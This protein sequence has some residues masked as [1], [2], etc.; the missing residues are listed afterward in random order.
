MIDAESIDRLRD[1]A[2]CEEVPMPSRTDVVTCCIWRH[3]MA[4]SWKI[5][6]SPRTTVLAHEAGLAGELYGE[7][8]LVGNGCR[9]G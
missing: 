6:G 3:A 1:R 9:W 7:C 8:L 2:K 4:G 5:T